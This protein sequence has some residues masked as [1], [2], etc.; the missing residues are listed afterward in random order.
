MGEQQGQKY[1]Y[2]VGEGNKVEF[3]N[4]T[5]GQD[6]GSKYTV[7][8][9]GV[10]AGE[11]VIIEGLQKVRPGMVVSPKAPRP[12]PGPTPGPKAPEKEGE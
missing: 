10:K 4:V 6:Y 11:K 8:A 1:V 9:S 3:R 12:T 5:V 7:I 2:V